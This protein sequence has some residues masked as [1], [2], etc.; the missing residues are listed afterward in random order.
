MPG[1]ILTFTATSVRRNTALLLARIRSLCIRTLWAPSLHWLSLDPRIRCKARYDIFL[2]VAFQQAFNLSKK[3]RF[4]DTHE[5][6][7]VPIQSGT[8]CTSDTMHIVFWHMRKFVIHNVRQAVDI[9]AACGNIRCDQDSH[10]VGFKIRECFRSCALR[11]VAV[12]R[13]RVYSIVV[14]LLRQSI[15]AMLGPGKDKY[16][17]PVFRANTVRQKFALATLIHRMHKLADFLY[18]RISWCNLDLN[19]IVQEA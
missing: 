17:A 3:L 8:S 2:D 1:R 10:L 6:D 11:L 9:Q 12:D 7:C 16:L 18:R 14:Q 5:R 4:V 15:R 19:G 13:N